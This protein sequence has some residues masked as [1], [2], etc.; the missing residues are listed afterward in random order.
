MKAGV[1]DRERAKEFSPDYFGGGK[2]S[3][4]LW[5]LFFTSV[6]FTFSFLS[7]DLQTPAI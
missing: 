3:V 5:L 6:S 4:P 2:G 7:A 1:W